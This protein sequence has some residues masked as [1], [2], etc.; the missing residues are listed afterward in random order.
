MSGRTGILRR[1]AFIVGF[2]AVPDFLRV[3]GV[4]EKCRLQS[5]LREVRAERADRVVAHHH[6]D[7]Q[8]RPVDEVRD[9]DEDPERYMLYRRG[10]LVHVVEQCGCGRLS[11]Q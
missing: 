5:D 1:A 6:L 4:K 9:V 10:S 2:A 7:R 3:D 8:D 11:C